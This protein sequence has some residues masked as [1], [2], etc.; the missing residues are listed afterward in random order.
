MLSK[1]VYLEDIAIEAIDAANDITDL[2]LRN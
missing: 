2:V 1:I